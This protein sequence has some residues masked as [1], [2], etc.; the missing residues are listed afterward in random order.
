M[1]WIRAGRFEGKAFREY[2][3][4]VLDGFGLILGVLDGFGLIFRGFGWF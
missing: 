2:F 4:G 1:T 3:L